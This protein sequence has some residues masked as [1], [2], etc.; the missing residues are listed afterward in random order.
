MCTDDKDFDNTIVALNDI[1]TTEK[2]L[3]G[4]VAAK[5]QVAGL[6]KGFDYALKKSG[7]RSYIEARD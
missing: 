3:K 5:V 6:V 2:I 1:T 4:K 7:V